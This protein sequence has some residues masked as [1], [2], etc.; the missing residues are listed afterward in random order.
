MT[1]LLLAFA[2][3]GCTGD[4]PPLESSAVPEGDWPCESC[5]GACMRAFDSTPEHS[6]ID[7]DLEY[8][9]E[10]PF[11]GNHNPCWTTWGAHEEAVPAENWLHNLEHGGV[12]FLYD[13]AGS[14]DEEKAQLKAYTATL[15]AG[16]WVLTPYAPSKFPF[17][18]VSWG[19]RLELGCFDLPAMQ[20]FFD[21][22]V[23]NGREDVTGNPGSSCM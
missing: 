13:C 23:A 21:Q 8:E 17:S 20:L 14:C 2:L 1:V 15:P 5:D 18:V 11:G 19:Q 16:R 10:P 6:H 7:G 4:D 9:E 3:A 22:N 12:V